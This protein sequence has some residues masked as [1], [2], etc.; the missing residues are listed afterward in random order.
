VG[1][2]TVSL[3]KLGSGDVGRVGGKNASLGEMISTLK[4]K[5]VRVPEGFATT[6]SAYREYVAANGI[7]AELRSRTDA[8]SVGQ[9]SLHRGCAAHARAHKVRSMNA[10]PHFSA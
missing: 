8:L 9:A 5:G 6:A 4:E 1:E 3:E 10:H 7:E 2:Y